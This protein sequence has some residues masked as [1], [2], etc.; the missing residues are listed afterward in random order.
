MNE[1]NTKTESYLWGLIKK[2]SKSPVAATKGGSKSG[3]V[4]QIISEFKDR[5]RSNISKWRDAGDLAYNIDDPR[6]FVLQDLYDNL[7][8]DGHY[9]ALR[10]I[11]MAAVTGNR[12]YIMDQDGNE[13]DEV[14]QQLQTEWFYNLMEFWLDSIYRKYSV[15]ELVDPVNMIWKP[16]PHRNICPQNQRIYFEVGGTQ[17]INY[18]DPK[19]QRNMIY[20]ESIHPY[21][22]MNDI[23]PQLIWKRNAQQVWADLSEKFGIPLVA[24]ETM[25]TDKKQLDQIQ[26][27]LDDMGQAANAILPEGTKITIYDGS[28]KGD[29]HKIFMEQ[30]KTTN[31]EMSKNIVGGTMVIDDGSSR[32]QSEVH[33]RTLDDKIAEKDRRMIEF[34]VNNKLIPMLRMHGFKFNDNERFVFDRSESLT[35]KEHWE[36]VQGVL[37][38]HEVDEQWISKTF[39]VPIVSKKQTSTP[40]STKGLSA[41]FQ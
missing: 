12:F 16:V 23:V 10:Q 35:L 30:I 24:A 17:F 34:T 28:T 21:G 8:S 20:V 38:T 39:N 32:S 3:L 31:D 27:A 37:T 18:S 41:N 13:N 40:S 1:F 2:E 25:H 22:I 19:F 33:E 15:V 26:S 5:T 14:T 9:M 29:P 6:W 4:T 7:M 36:I 11:R